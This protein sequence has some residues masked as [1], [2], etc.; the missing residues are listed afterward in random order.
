[1]NGSHEK[2]QTMQM[3]ASNFFN[4]VDTFHIK[5]MKDSN[6]YPKKLP[7]FHECAGI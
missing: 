2:N 7:C 4:A 3:F 5:I 6:S 1:M